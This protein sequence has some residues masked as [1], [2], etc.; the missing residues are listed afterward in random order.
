M[1]LAVAAIRDAADNFTGCMG[2]ATDMRFR[3]FAPAGATI[4]RKFGGTDLGLAMGKRL[5][6]LMGG[7]IGPTSAADEGST[8]CCKHPLSP[9][10]TPLV[11]TGPEAARVAPPPC[12]RRGGD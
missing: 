5:V 6:E 1:L 10:Q 4:T 11:A 9:D 8:F 12:A 2:T 3:E 7:K